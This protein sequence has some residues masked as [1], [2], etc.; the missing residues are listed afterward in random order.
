MLP[1]LPNPVS[2]ALA[3]VRLQKE[4]QCLG[5]RTLHTD[6]HSGSLPSL[7]HSKA[8][9]KLSILGNQH[10]GEGGSQGSGAL[11]RGPGRAGHKIG[12]CSRGEK[13]DCVHGGIEPG[14]VMAERGCH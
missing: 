6:R 3:C 14:V 7:E 10:V 5:Q 4:A 1:D 8:V 13:C 9:F 12:Q 11:R 2:H